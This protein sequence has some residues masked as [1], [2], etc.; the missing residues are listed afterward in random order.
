MYYGL[1]AADE[2]DVV[3]TMIFNDELYEEYLENC[4]DIEF[5][6]GIDFRI[7]EKRYIDLN[8]LHKK[9]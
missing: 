8:F 2:S 5:Q 1:S 6:L 4:S 3:S 9:I 7:L